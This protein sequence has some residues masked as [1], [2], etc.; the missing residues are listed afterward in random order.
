MELII[1][2]EDGEGKITERRISEIVPQPPAAVTAFCH[3][4]QGERTFAIKGILSAINPDSGE[5]VTDMYGLF[6][7]PSP[8]TKKEGKEQFGSPATVRIPGHSGEAYKGQRNK[9]KRELF[10]RFGHPVILDLYKKKF[11]ALFRHKCFKCGTKEFLDIDHHVPMILGGHL[12]P[13]N[14]VALC[15][16]C[17]NKKHDSHPKDFYTSEELLRLEP[18]LE[19]QW[20]IFDFEFDWT[21]WNKDKKAYL[22]TLGVDSGLVNEVLNNPDHRYYIEPSQ[23]MPSVTISVKISDD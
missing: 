22:L 2:Y 11:F 20:K 12:V 16:K 23:P 3:L 4:R 10:N 14:L 8:N 6:G 19:C 15:K 18:I 9:E 7:L 21:S 13:G 17:N 1:K 5:E